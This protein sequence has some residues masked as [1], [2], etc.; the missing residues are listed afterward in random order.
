MTIQ[1]FLS[2]FDAKKATGGQWLV[3]CPAHDD[4]QASLAVRDGDKGIVIRCHAGCSTDSIL[5]AMRLRAADLFVDKPTSRRREVASYDYADEAGVLLYQA[6][7]FEPKTFSQRRPDG[8]GGWHWNMKDVRRVVYRL[9]EIQG[10]EAVVIVEGEKDVNALWA[11]GIPATCNVAGAGKWRDEYAQNLVAAG[12]QRVVVIPDND[13]PG[14]QHAADVAAC[15]VAAGLSVKVLALPDT[16]EKGDVSDYLARH[17]KEELVALLKAAPAF[18]PAA[19]PINGA[20]IQAPYGPIVIRVSDVQSERVSWL[21]LRR[22]ARRKITLLIGDPGVGKSL[23]TIDAAGRITRGATWPDGGVIEHP[24]NVLFLAV[25]DGIADTIRPRLER[26]GADLDRVFV[27]TTI[28]DEGGERLP[29]FESD[30]QLLEEQIIRL[31]PALVVVDPVSSYLG[32]TDSYKDAD[33][34][35][36][37]SPLAALADRHDV[38][39]IALVHMTK[40]SK[41]GKALYRAMGSIAFAA[42]ARIVLAAGSDPEQPERCYLMPVK[43]NICPPSATLAYRLEGDASDPDGAAR[44]VWEGAPV[45]GVS[46][47]VILGGGVSPGDREQQQD[48]AEFL[49]ELLSDG[50]QRADQVLKAG[51]ANGYSDSTLNRAKRRAGVRSYKEGFKGA[52]YWELDAKSVTKATIRPDVTTFGENSTVTPTQSITSSKIVTNSNLTTFAVEDDDSEV[53]LV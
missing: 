42:V 10:R 26:A 5:A 21:W 43:Q 13:G 8:S 40:G 53:G 34:R 38:A 49:G 44:V 15:C 47:E 45:E 37:L 4:R 27:F 23:I 1:E 11:R 36:V 48:A 39:V 29:N 12:V 46:A 24:A 32:R 16:P 7:R 51:K 9:R 52:W 28:R 50:R 19:A 20:S 17:T 33:V 18:N 30:L 31:E 2:R 14:R 22:A 41:E 35:R 25:E 3:K 6:V